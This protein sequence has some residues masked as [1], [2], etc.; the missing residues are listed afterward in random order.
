MYEGS[1]QHRLHR[2]VTT[3]TRIWNHCVAFQ[4]T[5]YRLFKKHCH[6]FALMRHIAKVRNR[7]SD[8]NVVGSQCVQAVIEKLDLTYQ[9]FFRWIK[10]KTGPKRG[11]PKFKRS[12]GHGSVVF[13]QCGWAYL[14]DN[15]IRFG[16]HT[17]KFIK[18]REIEGK[19]KTCT[20]KRDSMNRFWVVFSCEKEESVAQTTGSTNTAGFDFG[21]KTFLTCSDGTAIESPQFF[22]AGASRVGDDNRRLATKKKGSNNRRKAKHRLIRSHER[23]AKRRT[24]WFFKL[25]HSLCD[26]FDTLYFETLNLE[27]MKRIWGRKIS[28]LALDRFIQ[29]LQWVASKRGKSV[30]FIG[31]WSPTSKTCNQCGHVQDMPLDARVFECENCHCSVCRDV[32][33]ALNIQAL[34][35]QRDGLGNVSH[36]SGCAIPA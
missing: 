33:A 1:K 22:K 21:L 36:G 16:R 10:S 19:I 35:H 14:G 15:R 12:A 31:R 30:K 2:L 5:H 24:D 18:S 17:Y 11:K 9:A 7:R 26:R 6:K 27:A 4:K 13:K 8:W 23:I 29:I 34:G 25:A 3:A 28:D 32:N 20:L